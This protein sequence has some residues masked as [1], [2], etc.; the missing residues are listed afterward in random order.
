M[1][2]QGLG[3]GWVNGSGVCGIGAGKYTSK[4]DGFNY[5]GWWVRSKL[6]GQARCW[7]VGG[8]EYEGQWCEGKKTGHGSH[9]PDAPLN[10]TYSAS[11]NDIIHCAHAQHPG[12]AQ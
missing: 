11:V 7:Q 9:P 3:A 2:R 4:V 12:S 10:Y 1:R 8:S 5:E 6:H